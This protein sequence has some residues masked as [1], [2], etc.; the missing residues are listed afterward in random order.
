MSR[1]IA[2]LGK[3]GAGK[4]F[5]AAHLAMAFGYLGDRTLL[6]GCDQKRDTARAVSAVSRPSL[7]ETLE[8]S[9]FSPGNLKLEELAVAVTDYVDVMELGPSQLLFGEYATVLEAAFD[10]FDMQEGEAGYTRV[11]YDVND[12]RFDATTAP[13]FKRVEGAIGVTTEAPESLFV[14]NRLL[15]AALIGGYEQGYPLRVAGVINNRSMDATAFDR[16]VE[17]TRCFPLLC[18]PERA[19][20]APLRQEHRT[21]FHGNAAE[22]PDLLIDGILKVAEILRAPVFNLYPVSPLE[23]DEIWDLA[24]RDPVP[25]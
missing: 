12:E 6:V 9:D 8:A 2:I 19:D 4:T 21:L 17:R 24:P 23:D 18:V 5:V 22:N 25:N 15:R 16:Y 11:V 3:A 20:L 7:V 14:L 13:L 1:N 10:W